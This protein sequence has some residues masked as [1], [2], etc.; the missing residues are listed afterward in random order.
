MYVCTGVFV[1]SCIQ[2]GAEKLWKGW[3]FMVGTWNIDSLIQAEQ[4]I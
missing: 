1:F 4:V 2:F 3:G